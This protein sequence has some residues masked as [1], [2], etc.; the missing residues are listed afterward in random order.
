M[1]KVLKNFI[2]INKISR[3][4][5]QLLIAAPLVF[6]SLSFAHASCRRP[7]KVAF[8]GD[9]QVDN[10]KE[11]W[12]A[13]KTVYKE[14]RE[15]RDLDMVVLLGDLVNDD[16]SLLQPTKESLDSLPCPWFCVPGNHDR[17]FYGKKKGRVMSLDGTVDESRHRDM[18][19]YSKVIGHVDTSF[20]KGGLRFILMNDVRQDGRLGY[21][22]GFLSRQ[23]A[24]IDSLLAAT[25]ADMT[26]VLSAHI[27]FSEFSAQDSLAH[28]ISSHPKVLLFCA[29]T[30]TAGRSDIFPGVEEVIAGAACGTFWRGE[31]D[32]YG[33]PYSI[34]NCG[35]P[36]GYYVASFDKKGGYSLEY[37]CVLRPASEEASA[38]ITKDGR[39]IVNVFGGS[40]SGKVE[41]RLPGISGWKA[42]NKSEEIA[43]EVLLA[44]EHNKQVRS[45][46]GEP[47]ELVPLRKKPSPHIWAAGLKEISNTG[48]SH[49][50]LAG[51]P[52]KIRYS[53]K[54]MSFKMKTS[55]LPL[56]L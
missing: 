26:A 11:L 49:E 37:K 33:I 29:H 34:M 55:L 41:V 56:N 32:S 21:Y 5:A 20:I 9:P 51:R 43:P 8:V 14:L 23:K 1:N 44:L 45:F 54:S 38:W 6:L 3:A 53:D 28:L 50:T 31:K 27:P 39:L 40:A 15:R 17:D 30:H 24:Y 47:E 18:A 22:G 16:V 7:F 13:R 2:Y 10:A 42:L 19:T 25:P 48:L 35:A 12:Y 46:K 4:G 36:R 52:V